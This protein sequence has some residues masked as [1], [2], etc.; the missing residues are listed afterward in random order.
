MKKVAMAFAI[1]MLSVGMAAAVDFPAMLVNPLDGDGVT[2]TTFAGGSSATFTGNSVVGGGGTTQLLVLGTPGSEDYA[3]QGSV[4]SNSS[5]EVG[6]GLRNTGF[7]GYLLTTNFAA[8]SLNLIRID[9]A[10]PTNLISNNYAWIN[11]SG[12][13]D[14]TFSVE[15][16]NLYGLLT[17]GVNTAEY[18][19]TDSSHASGNFGLVLF[20]TASTAGQAVNGTWTGLDIGAPVPE[21]GTIVMLV[22][23]ALSLLGWA[24]L[25]RRG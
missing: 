20:A 11:T 16:S 9:A 15:G 17:D 2:P 13:Y 6:F 25:R 23:G 8:G 12:T 1:V 4:S 10:A 21:P 14:M 19:I 7:N 18:N 22:V 5:S 3:L 24:G